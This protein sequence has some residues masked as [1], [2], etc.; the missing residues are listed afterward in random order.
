MEVADL[1]RFRRT[2]IGSGRAKLRLSRG[3]SGC[4]AL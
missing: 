1:T 3:F 4:P 2:T